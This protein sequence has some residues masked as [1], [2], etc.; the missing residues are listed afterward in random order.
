MPQV[1]RGS[2]NDSDCPL[3]RVYFACVSEDWAELRSCLK[4]ALTRPYWKL[5]LSVSRSSD[6]YLN[7]LSI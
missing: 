7:S 1:L 5:N 2:I 3:K 6:F 4:W